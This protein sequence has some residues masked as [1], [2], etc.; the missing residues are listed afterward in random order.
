MTD[1]VQKNMV[2]NLN[3]YWIDQK[4]GNPEINFYQKKSLE[5]LLSEKFRIPPFNSVFPNVYATEIDFKSVDEV[6]KTFI[7]YNL[8][9]FWQLTPSPISESLEKYLL[10]KDFRFLQSDPCMLLRHNKV[11]FELFKRKIE[12]SELSIRVVTSDVEMIDLYSET[13]FTG[14]G[15]QPLEPEFVSL[16]RNVMLNSLDKKRQYFLGFIDD[17]PVTTGMNFYHSG[18][19]GLYEITTQPSFRKHGFGTVMTMYLVLKAQEMNYTES[20]LGASEMGYPIYEKLGF[21]KLFEIKNF[22]NFKVHN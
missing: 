17:K 9:P 16:N 1:N 6:N 2:S 7:N 12:D 5:Y 11:D 10:S 8:A 21:E 3:Y 18:L 14:F 19:A 15:M 22:S 4:N 20:I 13:M